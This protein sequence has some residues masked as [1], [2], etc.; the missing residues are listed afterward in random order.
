VPFSV[1]VDMTAMK[2][3][4]RARWFNPASGAFVA[5]GTVPNTGPA[6]FTTQGDNGSTFDDWALVLDV[7]GP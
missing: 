4:A 1:T 3:P 7:P 2:A 5:I 6:T